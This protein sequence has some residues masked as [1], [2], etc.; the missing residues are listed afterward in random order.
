LHDAVAKLR[1]AGLASAQALA[2]SHQRTTAAIDILGQGVARSRRE[3]V[4]L[5]VRDRDGMAH[6]RVTSDV[7]ADGIATAA[8]ELAR[9]AGH[10]AAL[11]LPTPQVWGDGDD[12]PADGDLLGRVAKIAQRRSLSSRII[13]HAAVLDLDDSHVWSVDERNDLE[14]RRMRIRLTATHVAWNG[15]RPVVGE[16]ARA[17]TGN[18]DDQTLDDQ[19]LEAAAQAALQLITPG[20]FEDGEYGLALDPDVVASLTDAAARDL[21]TST[22]ARRPDVAK[23]LAIGAHVASSVITLVDDPSVVAAYGGF[24][25][26]D[27]GELAAPIMLVDR[28]AVVGRLADRAGVIA[29]VAKLAGRGVRAGNLARLESAASHLRLSPG[30]ATHEGLLANGF[31]LEGAR[32]VSIDPASD[33]LVIGIERARE[34]RGGAP[35]GRVYAEVELVGELGQLL[36]TVSAASKDTRTI[37]IREDTEAGPRWRSLEVPWLTARGTLRARRT[38]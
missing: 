16:A 23:R 7:S 10:G 27:E 5:A 2:V 22:A 3:G 25:F 34:V 19:E 8:R 11:R 28:G 1:A 26:D 13:Y 17:W 37:G 12:L 9:N 30:D 36:A 35:T 24:H 4:V 18:V 33:R 31:L 29:G 14:Q 15:T 20:S 32:D 21:L 38:A 6:E